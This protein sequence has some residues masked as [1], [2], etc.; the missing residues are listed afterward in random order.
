MVVLP[1]ALV[2]GNVRYI[3]TTPINNFHWTKTK[4]VGH[5]KI[6]ILMKNQITNEGFPKI[7]QPN[8]DDVVLL[9]ENAERHRLN[10]FHKRN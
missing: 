7:M 2:Y 5:L 10:L 4:G 1:Y 3:V 8:D 9:T 6:I